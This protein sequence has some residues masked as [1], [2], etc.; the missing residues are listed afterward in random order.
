MVLSDFGSPRFFIS[1]CT[2]LVSLGTAGPAYPKDAEVD[3][4]F[5]VSKIKPLLHEK[6]ISCHGALKQEAQLRLDTAALIRKGSENGS[7]VSASESKNPS[8]SIALIAR[9]RSHGSDRMPPEGEGT[10]FKKE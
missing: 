1:V 7:I 2:V 6:C 5:Y 9:L 8:D 10:P 3:A 4:G